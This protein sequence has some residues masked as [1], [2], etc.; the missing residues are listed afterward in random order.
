MLRKVEVEAKNTEEAAKKAAEMLGI[1]A[2]DFDIEVVSE[3]KKGLFGLG[4]TRGKVQATAW[5]KPEL[6]APKFLENILESAGIE[7]KVKAELREDELMLNIEGPEMGLLIGRHGQTLLALQ[8]LVALATNKGGHKFVRICLDIAGYQEQRRKEL[9]NIAQKAAERAIS[10]GQPVYLKPMTP[11]DRKIVHICL[12]EN[13]QITTA[14]EGE[15]PER[16]V[17]VRPVKRSLVPYYI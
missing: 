13:S 1:G 8:Y 14:S 7:G 17:V 9:E 11:S 10:S 4:G 3:D 12:R 16:Q 15:E 5:V 6:W 2:D